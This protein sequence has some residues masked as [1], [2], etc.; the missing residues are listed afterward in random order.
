MST[1]I[2]PFSL[3]SEYFPRYFDEKQKESPYVMAMFRKKIPKSMRDR[4]RLL[5]DD[6]ENACWK[7]IPSTIT[8][9]ELKKLESP[10]A[11]LST[12]C[13]LWR[14]GCGLF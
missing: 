5:E 3:I 8:D 6:D 4:D 12:V 13:Q 9:K 7:A 14:L 2:Q 11:W 10:R 1:P